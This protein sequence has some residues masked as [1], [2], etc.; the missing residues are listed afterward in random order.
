MK[1]KKIDRIQKQ[2]KKL[3]KQIIKIKNSKKKKIN[4]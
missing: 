2:I 1:L 4:K 3:N